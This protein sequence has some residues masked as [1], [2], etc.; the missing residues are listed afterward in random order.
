MQQDAGKEE[1]A[2]SPAPAQADGQ[3]E[4]GESAEPVVDTAKIAAEGEEGESATAAGEITQKTGDV[5]EPANGGG[6][7]EAAPV[8][9]QRDPQMEAGADVKRP[10]TD[11]SSSSAK[12]VSSA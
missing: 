7:T 11:Q 8:A 1:E 3:L 10:S 12:K 6:T 9:S 2:V 5:E 4:E